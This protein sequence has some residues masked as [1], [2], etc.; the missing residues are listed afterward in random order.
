LPLD[1][2]ERNLMEIWEC[3]EQWPL[4]LFDFSFKNKNPT[5]T[6]LRVRQP[7]H[8]YSIEDYFYGAK[9]APQ[10]NPLTFCDHSK[11]SQSDLLTERQHHMCTASSSQY[12]DFETHFKTRYQACDMSL[13]QSPFLT[14]FLEDD[15]HLNS[16]IN[17]FMQCVAA[18]LS[19]ETI[20]LA[21]ADRALA[22]DKT[23]LRSHVK[24]QPFTDQP[25]I[26]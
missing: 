25:I 6:C 24:E 3:N 23:T 7:F 16:L 2:Y 15:L 10:A 19:N 13:L 8:E 4:C 22:F 1:Q 5:F 14:T 21:S 9:S 11:L 26:N 12:K 20:E 17:A 18:P